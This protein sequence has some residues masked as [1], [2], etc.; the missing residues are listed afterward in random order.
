M[1]GTRESTGRQLLKK[2]RNLVVMRMVANVNY[3][4][5]KAAECFAN[6]VMTTGKLCNKIT[7]KQTDKHHVII[8]DD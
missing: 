7:S 6:M 3:V 5:S 8:K 2:S 4:I 1:A